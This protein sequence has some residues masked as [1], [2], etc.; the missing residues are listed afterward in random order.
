MLRGVLDIIVII[1]VLLISLFLSQGRV[2]TTTTSLL[3]LAFC[4]FCLCFMCVCVVQF[5]L[6]FSC[7]CDFVQNICESFL[8]SPP[9]SLSTQTPLQ[10]SS[11]SALHTL[12]KSERTS[13]IALSSARD[14]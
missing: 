5:Y 8:V 13:Y 11:L 14:R 2:E 6:L 3:L 1:I 9:L 12:E 7:A 10:S 4:S